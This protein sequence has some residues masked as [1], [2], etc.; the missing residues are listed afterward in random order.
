ILGRSLSVFLCLALAV[1]KNLSTLWTHSYFPL[2]LFVASFDGESAFPFRP[3]SFRRFFRVAR[4]NAYG[5]KSAN[6]WVAF[7]PNLWY[8]GAKRALDEEDA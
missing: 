2:V 4:K 5:I 7:A 1:R 6:Q 8:N 3:R